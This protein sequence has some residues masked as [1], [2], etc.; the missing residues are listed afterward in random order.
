MLKKRLVAVLIL[1]DGQV[2]QSVRFKHTNVIHYDALHAMEAFNKWSVDEIIILNVSRDSSSRDKF[3]EIVE[4]IS[5]HCFVPLAVGGWV[6]DEAYAQK[7]LRSGADKLILNTAVADD[8]QLVTRLASRYGSQSIVASID[9][10]RDDSGIPRIAVDRGS[11]IISVEPKEWAL[12]AVD[13]GVGEI[14][15]NSVDHDG[16]RKGY[17]LESIKRV[18]EAV[19]V[20]VVAFG[21]VFTWDHLV[22]GINAGA[23]AVAAANIFHYT[24]Q[25]T[26]K[27]KSHLA[28]A[29][30]LV[31]Q[32]GQRLTPFT[33]L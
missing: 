4:R 33:S 28:G 3:S 29:G 20:P 30:V 25:S 2:V 1:R 13:Q 26:R 16:A 6:N 19:S 17:D 18:C 7:L 9:V 12:T 23:S 11:R 24:E 10:K 15:L 8:P 21:G 14:F 31:R 5:N 22:Q 27:A 32:Q